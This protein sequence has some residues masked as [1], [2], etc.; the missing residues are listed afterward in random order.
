MIRGTPST[1]TRSS[2]AGTTSPVTA[3]RMKIPPGVTEPGAIASL[4]SKVAAIVV[5]TPI[6]VF[7]G[8][9]ARTVG[10]AS[11]NARSPR[12]NSC[13]FVVS[14]PEVRIRQTNAG[15]AA[16]RS[17][18]PTGMFSKRNLP[19]PSERTKARPGLAL[20]EA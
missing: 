12:S 3:E 6:A 8:V 1:S 10:K 4:N 15:A 20:W 7:A 18:A 5:D 13:P 19:C 9:T 11:S 14:L 2:V 16:S 17:N